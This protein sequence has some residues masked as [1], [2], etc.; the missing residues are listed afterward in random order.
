MA[1]SP[2]LLLLQ[3][4]TNAAALQFKP[5]DIVHP[6]AVSNGLQASPADGLLRCSAG[7]GATHA[8]GSRAARVLLAPRGWAASGFAEDRNQGATHASGVPACGWLT[9]V[10]LFPL[11]SAPLSVECDHCH[12]RGVA[13]GGCGGQ[14]G[15][16]AHHRHYCRCASCASRKGCHGRGGEPVGSATSAHTRWSLVKCC[17]AACPASLPPAAPPCPSQ[18]LTPG[19][20]H[21][22]SRCALTGGLLAMGAVYA[23]SLPLLCVLAF[24]ATL[25]GY[26][27][28]LHLACI[29]A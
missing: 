19:P 1:S 13:A 16:R 5:R 27:A 28:G 21:H 22:P 20:H 17:V 24:A 29:C 9:P 25:V 6:E 4:L 18:P 14:D 12:P 23:N 7:T 3:P 8:C 11:L 15:H 26:L 2:R 10:P